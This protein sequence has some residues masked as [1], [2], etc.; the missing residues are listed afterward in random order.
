MMPIE[1]VTL[2]E[3]YS[4]EL[5]FIEEMELGYL[6]KINELKVEFD[7]IRYAIGDY[8]RKR[9]T[10]E[11]LN[12]IITIPLRKLLCDSKPFLLE[13]KSDFKMPRL[14]GKVYQ[15]PSGQKFSW[16]AP[17]LYIGD[18]SEWL[19][20]SDWKEQI[21]AWYESS[22]DKMPDFMPEFTYNSVVKKLKGDEKR[23]FEQSFQMI[24][25]VFKG[26]VEKMYQLINPS[27]D[28]AKIY[29]SLKSLGYY[30]LSLYKF[31]KYLGDKKGAHIDTGSSVEIDALVDKPEPQFGYTCIMY[32]ALE[33]IYAAQIQISELNDYCPELKKVF[34]R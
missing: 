20:I 19:S 30:D 1:P 17:P 4:H 16:L 10:Q 28:K 22:I 14:K 8:F 23:K 12:R 29:E 26:T 27:K 24:D 21:I 7:I 18:F 31:I 25:A 3:N 9:L 33:M 32:I 15:I 5:N 6:G 11:M 2:P 34:K 13:I